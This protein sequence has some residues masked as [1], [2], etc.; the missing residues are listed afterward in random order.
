MHL[1]LIG[2]IGPAATDFY[3]K[4]L[5]ERVQGG[6]NTLELT[7]VHASGPTLLANFLAGDQA[8]QGRIFAALTERDLAD[9]TLDIAILSNLRPIACETE[10]AL[11]GA[12]QPDHDG[13][14]VEAGGRRALFLP[15]VWR[16]VHDPALFVRRLLEKA[17]IGTRRWPKDLKAW[18]FTTE[19][20][21]GGFYRSR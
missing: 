10:D 5:V 4:G 19:S 16:R 20:F 18:R 14:F 13:L 8:T 3:Y 15:V 7:V 21:D 9:A 6:G 12:L 1:G 11:I 2:G 17:E